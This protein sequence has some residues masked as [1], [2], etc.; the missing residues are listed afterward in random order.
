M[1]INNTATGL[2]EQIEAILDNPQ[3]LKEL[4]NDAR[5]PRLRE[6]SRKLNI[7]MESAGDA[8]HRIMNAVSIVNVSGS[9]TSLMNIASTTRWCTYR[10]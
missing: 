5:R 6:A 7:A 8:T 4:Q 2:V 10:H 1:A 3:L 9:R